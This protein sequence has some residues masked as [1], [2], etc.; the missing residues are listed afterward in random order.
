MSR[1]A[2]VPRVR[3]RIPGPNARDPRYSV[4]LEEP[5]LDSAVSVHFLLVGADNGA[6]A[7]VNVGV[8]LGERF[9]RPHGKPLLLDSLPRPVDPATVRY[10]AERF[11]SYVSFARSYLDYQ[12]GGGGGKPPVR[13]QR[14]RRL[15]DD[16]LRAIARQYQAFDRHSGRPVTE[17]A[18]AHGVNPSTAS[19][20]VARARERGM[21]DG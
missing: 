17:L 5:G 8:E 19:R 12:A 20:W 18:A 2:L 1:P 21:L 16:D 11:P 13:K 4:T 15:T 6:R 14:R 7:W 3:L 9:E 10:V